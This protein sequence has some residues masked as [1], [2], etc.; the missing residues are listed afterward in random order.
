MGFHEFNVHMV[1]L[2]KVNKEFPWI[3]QFGKIPV[4]FIIV[5]DD[6]PPVRGTGDVIIPVSGS[7]MNLSP[8]QIMILEP[9]K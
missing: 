7:D 4:P 1:L 2:C 3:K 8:R 5:P 6:L 9:V